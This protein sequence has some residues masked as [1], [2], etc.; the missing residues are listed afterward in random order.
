MARLTFSIVAVLT[1]WVG[2]KKSKLMMTLYMDG[3]Q[4]SSY[5]QW[6]SKNYNVVPNRP[7][8]YQSAFYFLIESCDRHQLFPQGP[9]NSDILI[10]VLF[11]TS[12][13]VP[14]VIYTVVFKSSSLYCTHHFRPKNREWQPVFDRKKILVNSKKKKILF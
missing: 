8:L 5:R 6:N 12:H 10:T 4:G 14:P 9:A 2:Q 13:T 1:Q 7:N 11:Y 3:P